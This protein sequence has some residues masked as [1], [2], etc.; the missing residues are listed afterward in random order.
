[1]ATYKDLDLQFAPHPITGDV[2]VKRDASAVIQSIKNLI[3]TAPGEILW[4]PNIGGGVGK[5]MFEPNDMMF[6]MQ[7]Y[8]KITT[9]I[10]MFEPRAEIADLVIERFENGQGVTISLKFY[11]LNDPDP[12]TVTVPIKRIR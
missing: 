2:V 12:I 10:N 3:R 5:A 8:D 1:M 6:K 7:L 4:E 11:I 9:T